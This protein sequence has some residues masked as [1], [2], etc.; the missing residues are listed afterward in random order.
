M[1]TSG[2]QQRTVVLS[3]GCQH[4]VGRCVCNYACVGQEFMFLIGTAWQYM[5]V[6]LLL[7]N[8]LTFLIYDI[9]THNTCMSARL[10]ALPPIRNFI[11]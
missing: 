9:V 7:L 10:L 8:S 3:V 11:G 6:L 1:A 4:H 5:A 2:M